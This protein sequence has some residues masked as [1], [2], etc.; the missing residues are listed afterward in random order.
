MQVSTDPRHIKRQERLQA[1]FVWDFRHEDVKNDEYITSLISHIQEVDEVIQKNAPIWKIDE[2]AKIDV[3]ILRLAVY[4]FLFDKETP[5]KT[6]IDEAVELA[7]E[8]GNDK[9][10]GFINGVLGKII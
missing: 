3:A 9:S 2:M 10:P 1:I 7:K 5:H 6:I 4:E 8:F